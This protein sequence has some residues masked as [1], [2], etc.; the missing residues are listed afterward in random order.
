MIANGFDTTLTPAGRMFVYLPF[1][2]S[3]TI[4]DQN[5][6]VRLVDTLRDALGA[7]TID[8]AS[9]HRDVIARFRRF[10]HRNATLGR[11]STPAEEAYLAQPGAGF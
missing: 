10:P 3:E 7:K 11:V 2:H 9:R 8:H 5:E 4:E 1:E 6:S